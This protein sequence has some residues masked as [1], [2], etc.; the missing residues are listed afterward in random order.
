MFSP[1]TKLKLYSF[2]LS[3]ADL[4]I[5]AHIEFWRFKDCLDKYPKIAAVMKKVEEN[6]N[7][8]KYL[9]DQIANFRNT[10]TCLH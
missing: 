10:V 1:C 4:A 6:K 2:Q 7:V 3:V 8:A 9:K 5:Y